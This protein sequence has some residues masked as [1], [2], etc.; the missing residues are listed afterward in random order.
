[1]SE[2]PN[3]RPGLPE[4]KS[5]QAGRILIVDDEESMRLFLT[6]AMSKQGYDAAAAPDAESAIS[7]LGQQEF[8]LAILDIGLPGISGIEAIARIR[9]L[10]PQ[11]VP[12]IM[13]ANGTKELALEAVK[14]GAYDFFVKPFKIE[15]LNVV[16]QRALER[17]KLQREVWQLEE[18]LKKRYEFRN[19]IGN[20]G[21]MQ[22]VFALINKVINTDVTVLIYGESG[23]GKELVAQAVHYHSLRKS[24]PF[25]KLNC[26]A[27]PEGLLESELFGHE[28]GAFTGASGMKPGK[29]ELANTGTIFLD[30]I[31]DMTLSTQAK[32]LRVLQERELERVGSTKTVKIDVRVIAATNKDL[33]QAVRDRSFREDLF[34]RL[35]V[36]AIHMPPLRNRKEDI[37]LLVEHFLCTNRRAV[38]H[39]LRRRDDELQ[40]LD[41]SSINEGNGPVAVSREAMDLLLEYN[42]PG[43]VR[44]LE[45]FVQRAIV[46]AE[47]DVIVPDCLPIHI[48]NI[49]K[50]N[51]FSI[52][53]A[54]NLD[55]TMAN[56]EKQLIMDTLR[57]TGGVQSKAARQLGITQR[58][59]WHRVKKLN[60]D[61]NRLRVPED[62]RDDDSGGGDSTADTPA[63][64][65]YLMST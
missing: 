19:I 20:S 15:E 7:L 6:E 21:P 59:L 28:K 13:T 37:P 3:K 17:R 38:A 22:E 24:R 41:S 40:L 29:F 32:I 12:I 16:I 50:K 8:D 9:Q 48:Q 36:F 1:M 51:K 2:Q 23:T 10:N 4:P 18:R 33:A 11:I 54:G 5:W 65:A 57:E 43:N 61:V 55:Q 26:V 62:R 25:V 45:N 34:F 60:I 44:E 35:N 30:E 46:M 64:N 39:P 42:W 27:I 49:G 31:G 47:G 56:I 63:E 14:A 58:S 53:R 52:Q